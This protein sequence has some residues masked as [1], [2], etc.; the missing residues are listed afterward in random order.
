MIDK[1]KLHVYSV[2]GGLAKIKPVDLSDKDLNLEEAER[3]VYNTIFYLRKLK[4]VDLLEEEM[5]DLSGVL[6]AL[7]Y[8]EYQ[9]V[10][11]KI[12]EAGDIEING[13]KENL[14]NFPLSVYVHMLSND[15]KEAN[16]YLQIINTEDKCGKTW[17]ENWSMEYTQF[18][19]E[20]DQAEDAELLARRGR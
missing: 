18:C 1:R 20:R 12:Y 10:S 11:K 14:F 9:N 3:M 2:I 13:E 6:S 16:K 5:D 4:G 8:V 15:P 7:G 19:Y 17:C